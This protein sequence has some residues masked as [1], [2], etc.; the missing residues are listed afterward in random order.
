MSLCTNDCLLFSFRFDG[1]SSK[2][3][4]Q[5]TVYN[6]LVNFFDDEEIAREWIREKIREAKSKGLKRGMSQYVTECALILLLPEQYMVGFKPNLSRQIAWI[7][8]DNIRTKIS[9]PAAWKHFIDSFLKSCGLPHLALTE[10][11]IKSFRGR[12]TNT[13][14]AVRSYI[15]S[16]L[17]A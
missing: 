16:L 10:E 2:I 8:L 7:Y 9:I 12:K 15:L 3:S 13:S 4:I 5:P 6:H 11:Q 17:H 1:K 14:E